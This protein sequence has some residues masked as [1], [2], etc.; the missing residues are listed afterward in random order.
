MLEYIPAFQYFLTLE[1]STNPYSQSSCHSAVLIAII[2]YTTHVT[3]YSFSFGEID[4]ARLLS[5][6]QNFSRIS[7]INKHME[8]EKEEV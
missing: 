5:Y 6:E 3:E 4:K 2:I 8:A 1:W 7:I